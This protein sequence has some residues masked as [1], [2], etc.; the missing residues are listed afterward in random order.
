MILTGN[1]IR[2]YIQA[3]IITIDP[4]ENLHFNP[5]SVDLTLGTEVAV[6]SDFTFTDVADEWYRL[7]RSAIHQDHVEAGLGGLKTGHPGFG[8]GPYDGRGLSPNGVAASGSTGS[9]LDVKQ[10]PRL[11]K[12]Q[13][14]PEVGWIIQPGVGYLMHTAERVHTEEFVPVLDGKSSIGR[15][16]IKVHETAGFG[17][18]GFNGQYTLEVTSLFPVRVYPGMRFCQMRFH[19]FEGRITSYQELGRYRGEEA[20]GAVGSRISETFGRSVDE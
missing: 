17:D 5:A 2:Q 10:P 7:E 4:S 12:W 11:R 6:Y 18:P 20:Q 8:V 9:A 3:G 1:A 16:F 13:M 14:D 15:L 19:K